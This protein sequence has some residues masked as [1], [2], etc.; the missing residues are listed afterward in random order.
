M[1]K[2]CYHSIGQVMAYDKFYAF[3]NEICTLLVLA[4]ALTCIKLQLV[5]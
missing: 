3:V 1:P 4:E 5:W 2:S